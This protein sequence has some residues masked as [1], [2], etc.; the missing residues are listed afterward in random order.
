MSHD[1][2][3][4]LSKKLIFKKPENEIPEPIKYPD[5]FSIQVS[6]A[7]AVLVGNKIHITIMYENGG[8]E[9]YHPSL[10]FMTHAGD[11][12]ETPVNITTIIKPKNKTVDFIFI[13]T[14]RGVYTF[15]LKPF[16]Q[17]DIGRL[18]EIHAL[19]AEEYDFLR[20]LLSKLSWPIN[21]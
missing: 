13:P 9:E 2:S 15:R 17:I 10:E 5:Q 1:S 20:P 14:D 12:P 21:L 8:Y 4:R 18:V 7:K 19:S 16:T 6:P 11:H 3:E